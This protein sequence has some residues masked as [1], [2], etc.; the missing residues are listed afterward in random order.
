MTTIDTTGL[1]LLRKLEEL[2]HRIANLAGH[3]NTLERHAAELDDLRTEV[4]K[5]KIEVEDMREE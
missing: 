2:D 4:A 5:L 1:Q 3:V